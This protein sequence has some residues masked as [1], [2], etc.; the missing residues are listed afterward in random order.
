MH[1]IDCEGKVANGSVRSYGGHTRRSKGPQN[2]AKD[3]DSDE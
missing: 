3:T 2:K 1:A